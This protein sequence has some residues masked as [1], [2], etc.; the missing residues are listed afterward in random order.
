M[1]TT[2]LSD[3]EALSGDGGTKQPLSLLDR[4]RDNLSFRSAWS[5]MNGAMGDL[6]TYIPIVLSL[7]LSR[8]LDLGTP[9]SSSPASSHAVTGIV[10]VYPCRSSP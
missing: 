2:A 7:A 5:E 4:A 6:G 9:P 8:H 1:A 10:Y 3:P